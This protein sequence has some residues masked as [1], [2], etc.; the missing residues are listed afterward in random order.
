MGFIVQEERFNE[1]RRR[2]QK[3]KLECI[4]QG[5][6]NKT[7]GHLLD[8]SE[9]GISIQL[10]EDIVLQPGTEVG[11]FS[12]ESGRLNGTVIWQNDDVA[13]IELETSSNSYAQTLSVVRAAQAGLY[14]DA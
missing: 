10:G 13:G 2:R 11:I 7:S 9:L 1:R 3:L 8:I 4:V 6:I 12:E 14:D 5:Q